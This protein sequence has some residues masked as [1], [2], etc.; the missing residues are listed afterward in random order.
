MRSQQAEGTLELTVALTNKGA[1]HALPAGLPSRRLLIE[2][3]ALGPD[4]NE[5]ARAQQSLGQHFL[6]ADGSPAAFFEAHS[7][8]ED[9][10]LAAG[11]TRSL[12]FTLATTPADSVHAIVYDQPLDPALASS[13]GIEAPQLREIAESQHKVKRSP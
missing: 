7:R 3:I 2:V 10:R 9:T 8:G 5:L 12:V 13:W 11:E 4:G 1:G 6:R